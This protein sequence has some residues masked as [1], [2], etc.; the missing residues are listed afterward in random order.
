MSTVF[1]VVLFAARCVLPAA[2]ARD[3]LLSTLT[4]GISEPPEA[5]HNTYL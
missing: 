1:Y 5:T 3:W 4:F 2:V